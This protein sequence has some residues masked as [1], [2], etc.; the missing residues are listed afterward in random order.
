LTNDLKKEKKNAEDLRSLNS[1]LTKENLKNDQRD[2]NLENLIKETTNQ[3]NQLQEEIKLFNAKIIEMETQLNEQEKVI[4]IKEEM[5]T[6][7]HKRNF[8]LQNYKSVYDYQ[9]TT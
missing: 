7:S 2:V 9:V 5:I 4:D 6:K 8:H 3:N 1:K